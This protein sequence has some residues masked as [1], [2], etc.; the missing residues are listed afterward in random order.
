ME[1]LQHQVGSCCA[2]ASC[3]HPAP[4]S[5]CV[6]YLPYLLLLGFF[7]L[8]F[9]AILL[10]GGYALH[11]LPAVCLPRPQHDVLALAWRP[12]GK[13]LASSTLDGQI[14][15]WDPHEASLQVVTAASTALYCF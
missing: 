3:E 5:P 14:Y 13:M 2:C 9:L 15:F 12:D 4:A 10:S 7:M 8:I 11:A 6:A 1:A